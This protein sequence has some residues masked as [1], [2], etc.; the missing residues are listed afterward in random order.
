M[1]ILVTGGAGYIGS[2]TTRALLDGGHDVV[3]LD[4]LEKGHAAAVDPRARL[5]VGDVG[6]RLVLD[7]VLPGCHAVMHLAGY[8]EVGESQRDPA[9]YFRGNAFKPLA[10]LESMVENNVGAIVFSSTA[11]TYGEPAQ[12]PISEDA[13]T[14][15]VNAYGASKLMFEEALDWFGRAHGIMSVRLRYFNAAGAWPDGSIGESHDPETHLIPRILCAMAAGENMFEVYGDDYDTPDGT[16]VRDYVHVCDLA[17]AHRLSLERLGAGGR[18]GVFNLGSGHG[19]S[20]LQ[21][22]EACADVTGRQI[23]VAFGPRREGDPPQLVAS[24]E[25]ARRELGWA[26]KRAELKVMIE[27]AWRWHA[28]HPSGYGQGS[29]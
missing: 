3:V 21:V 10:M 29:A 19:Y 16:C 6:D 27:D 4:T 1:K 12:V 15:P 17:L 24:P 22:V 7:R 2:V 11:A 28:L 8:I 9:R 18:G 14:K 20:N 26:P 13:P 25:R 23:E 5:E